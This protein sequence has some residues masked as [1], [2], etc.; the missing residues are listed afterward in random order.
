M[1]AISIKQVNT[2]Y[3]T[4]RYNKLHKINV[5]NNITLIKTLHIFI[6]HKCM[7]TILQLTQRLLYGYSGDIKPYIYIF[8]LTNS[9]NFSIL[10]YLVIQ[11]P[12]I[13]MH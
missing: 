9:P 6:L 12:K 5:S 4:N 2:N 11:I 10:I 13:I 7:D 1:A 3:N 8:L